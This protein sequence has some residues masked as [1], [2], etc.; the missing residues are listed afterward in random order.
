MNNVHG[1]SDLKRGIEMESTPQEIEVW[2]ILP[3][4]RKEIAANLK[5]QQMR[6][7]DIAKLLGITESAVS[8]YFK[9]K[10]AKKVVFGEEMKKEIENSST[11]I[12]NNPNSVNFEVQKLLKIVRDK[13]ILCETHKKLDGIPKNCDVCFQL[14]QYNKA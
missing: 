11:K 13:K 1:Q 9:S 14:K 3:A 2:Y 4:V 7:K 8:Q 6:Q 5:K 10:R 12:K